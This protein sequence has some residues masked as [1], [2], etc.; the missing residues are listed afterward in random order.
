MTDIADRSGAR[1]RLSSAPGAGPA[2]QSA[3]RMH[4]A[5]LYRIGAV[6]FGGSGVINIGAD[7]L[8][9]T[10]VLNLIGV[11]AGILGLPALY[12][13]H[14][15]TA[16]LSGLLAALLAGA[17]LIGIVGLLFAQAAIFPFLPAETVGILTAGPSGLA[18]FAGVVVYVLGVLAFAVTGWRAG[19]HPRP[20]LLLWAAGTLPTL[21]AIALPA[22]VMTLAEVVAGIGVLWLATALWQGAPR[23]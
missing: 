11:V 6:L 18:I 9:G 15:A 1:P 19:V 12:L 20:A 2:A 5:T 21:A 10:D 22:V 4:D 8:P 17:G 13:A 14:R 7:V 3:G 23:A 16:G